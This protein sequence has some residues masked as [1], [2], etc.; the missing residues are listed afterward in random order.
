MKLEKLIAKKVKHHFSA[1]EKQV[2]FNVNSLEEH[3]DGLLIHKSDIIY[4]EE[5]ELVNGYVREGDVN[6]DNAAPKEVAEP[7][8]DVIEVVVNQETLDANPEFVDAGIE[9]GEIIVVDAAAAAE[10]ISDAK[11]FTAESLASILGTPETTESV[12]EEAGKDIPAENKEEVI[13]ETKENVTEPIAETV[14]KTPKKKA[15]AKK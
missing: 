8:E 3:Y 6:M 9:V 12:L 4:L 13:T 15:A 1:K 10:P 7:L 5:G 14:V 2:L 11:V